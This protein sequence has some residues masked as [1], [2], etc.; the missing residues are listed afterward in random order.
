MK[1]YISLIFLLYCFLVIF[2]M[3]IG[4]LFIKEIKN[5]QN[6]LWVEWGKPSSVFLPKRKNKNLYKFIFFNNA[7]SEGFIGDIYFYRLS[8]LLMISTVL[9]Q[10]SFL[11]IVIVF[12]FP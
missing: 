2:N 1:D 3:V 8:K 9:T 11:I 4:N 6:T 5:N 7:N 12:L 10:T